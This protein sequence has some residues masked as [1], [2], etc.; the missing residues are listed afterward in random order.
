MHK[1]IGQSSFTKSAFVDHAIKAIHGKNTPAAAVT[2]LASW[3]DYEFRSRSGRMQ[4][5]WSSS[6]YRWFDGTGITMSG[7]YCETTSTT[8]TAILRSAGIAARPFALDYNKTA[9][10]GESGQIGTVFEYDHATMIWYND[11]WYAQRAY[12]GDEINNVYYPWNSGNTGAYLLHE[13]DTRSG[14]YT[15]YYGDGN[16]AV[17]ED[18]NFKT[19]EGVGTVNTAWPIPS[20]EFQAINRDYSWDSKYPLRITQ[21]PHVDTLNCQMWKGDNWAPGEWRT[22]IL[23]NP[24][25]RDETLTYYLPTGVPDPATPLE[26]WPYNPQPTACSPSTPT[27][28]CNAFKASW[29]TDTCTVVAGMVT[30][31]TPMVQIADAAHILF[32]PMMSFGNANGNRSIQIGDIIS[33]YGVDRDDDGHFDE[34]VI[35][36]EV[37]SDRVAGFQLGGLLQA[38]D[39]EIRS[40]DQFTLEKGVQTIKIVFDGQQ[41]GDHAVD[42]P[43]QVTALWA[44]DPNLAILAVIDPDGMLDYQKLSY[45]TSAFKAIEFEYLDAAF[46][47]EYSH[48]G[49]DRDG[50]GLYESIIINVPLDIKRPG[51]FL[52]EGDIYDGS[53]DFVGQAS[54]TGSDPNASLQFDVSKTQ[55]PYSL[56]HLNLIKYMGPLIDSRFAPEYLIEDL[57]GKI[58]VGAVSIGA[59]TGGMIIAGV[60][61]TGTYTF[62]LVDTN[63]NG[64]NDILRV[65]V[66]V[67]VTDSGGNYRIEGLL[68]DEYGTQVAWA[69]SAPQALSV[70][71]GTMTLD[72]DGKMLYDQLPLNGTRS[73]KLVAVKIF[74]NNLSS[75]TLESE[76]KYATTT[77]AYSRNQFE[78]SSPAITL[79]K[80]DLES[81]TDQWAL[82]GT[83]WSLDSGTWNSWTNSWKATATVN[84]SGQLIIAAP[85]DLTDYAGAVLRF[86]HAYRLGSVNDR[87]MLQISTD[88]GIT[89]NTLATYAG[90]NTTPHWIAEEV[91]LSAYGEMADVRVRFNATRASTNGLLWYVDNVYINAWP[92]VK[93]AS[94]T[95]PDEVEAGVPAT[96]T[97][98]YT[99]I[100]TSLPV[101]FK[102]NFSGEEVVTAS[103]TVNLTIPASGEI[104]VTLTVSNPYDS[105]TITQT[106]TVAANSN[107]FILTV[108]IVPSASGTVQ[109]NPDQVAF[110][111]GTSVTLTAT[112]AV[113]YT[114]GG[115]S[116]GGCS[117]SGSCTL[118][119]NE[120]KTV[121]AT[122]VPIEYTLTIAN[123]GLGEV[124]RIPDQTTYH[125]GDVVQLTAVPA[126]TYGFSHWEGDLAGS[127]NPANITIYGNKSI[128][129]VFIQ[130]YSLAANTIG[131]G[132]VTKYPD[133]VT[134]L[135][136]EQVELTAFPAVNWDFSTWNGA[137]TGGGTCSVIM[138]SNKEVTATFSQHQYNL[139]VVVTEGTTSSVIKDPD[140]A[141]Y[142]YGQR[143]IL[144]AVPETGWSFSSWTRDLTGSVNPSVI[145]IDGDKTVF[146]NFTH[147]TYSFPAATVLPSTA[148]G[149]VTKSPNATSY[150]YGAVVTVTATPKTG[151]EFDHWEGSCTGTEN[152]CVVTVDGAESVKAYFTSAYT[153]IVNTVGLGAV[154]KS[155][156]KL[157]YYYGDVVTLTPVG[158]GGWSFDSWTGDLTGNINPA[159]VTI[160]GNKNITAIFTED[161][162]L[163]SITINGSGHVDLIPP[164]LYLPEETPPSPYYTY[165]EMPNMYAIAHPGWTFSNWT[166]DRTGTSNPMAI[167]MSAD[168]YVTAHFAAIPYTFTTSAVGSGSISIN[169]EQATYIYGDVV[170]VTATPTEGWTFS[171]WSG[172]CTGSGACVV[173]VDG[174]ESVTAIFT[175]G[176]GTKTLSVAVTGSGTVTQT[177]PPPYMDGATV[178]LSPISAT[179]WHFVGWTG[180]CTGV[181]YCSVTMDADKTVGA[182]FAL[183]TYSLTVTQP[184]YGS[185]LPIEGTF[186][187]GSEVELIATPIENYHFVSW[188]GACEGQTI[189]CHVTMDSDK[190]VS[191]TFT[192][193]TF[194][195]TVTQP[196]NGSISP[197]T[198]IYDFG[199]VVELTATPLENY[200]FVEWTGA[201]SGQPTTTCSVTVDKDTAVSAVFAIDTHLLT[202][203]QTPGGTIGPATATYDYGTVVSLTATAATGYTFTQWN[204]DCT[205]QGNPCTIT[206][207]GPKYVS[208]TFTQ[209][210]RTLTIIYNP[211]EGG[212]TTVPAAGVN[213]YAYGT[214]VDVFAYPAVGYKFDHWSGSCS[215]TG[216]CRLTMSSNRTVTAWFTPVYQN[217]TIYVNPVGGGTTIP[218][219]GVNSYLEGSVVEVAATAATG[220]VFDYWS[221]ACTGSGACTVTMDMPKS[222]TAH[223]TAVF[224][225]LT[226]TVDPEGGGTTTPSVGLHTYPEG[227]VVFIIATPASGY[228]FDH[229]SGACTGSDSTCSVTMDSNKDVTA[230][231]VEYVGTYIL[232][233]TQPLNG[234]IDPTGGEYDQ[235]EI[236]VLTATADTGYH[237]VDWTGDCAEQGNPCTLTMDGDKTVSATFE[238]DA[239]TLMVNIVGSGTVA[240]E[241]DQATYTYGNEVTLTATPADGWSFS[242][243]G[244]TCPGTGSCVVT[245]DDNK[246]VTATFTQDEY[247]LTLVAGTGGTVSKTP[248]QATYHLGDTVTIAASADAGYTFSGWTDDYVGSVSP[249]DIT[250]TGDMTV[251]ANYTQDEYALTI[252]QST[253]GTIAADPAGPY[254]LNDE[255]SVTA[256]PDPGYSFTGWTGD[257]LGQGNP[258]TL[259]MDGPRPSAPPS[260]RTST[261]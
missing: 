94:F 71:N 228:V 124:T 143:V 213:T 53:G 10:H 11:T 76:A 246:S 225:D 259:V 176:T 80:D 77:P 110:D 183:N 147:P 120:N 195:L 133:K 205:G 164:G 67:T 140:Q 70:G 242:D 29:S 81:G 7:G 175:Q 6:M 145:T 83:I 84:S 238:L 101:T 60:D 230:T 165:H 169:P 155:P 4:N 163:L 170:T 166:G 93:T 90:I 255:V 102:W 24:S 112:P 149:T 256:T 187:Y 8:Y 239:Y 95:H 160:N 217:L 199:T 144:T 245:M 184:A 20:A 142:T 56:E 33:D 64:L 109:R 244:G 158:D 153:L 106:V 207:D 134:Y 226:I 257:C 253:G 201:C 168:K 103:P 173:T 78:P 69:V 194:S 50:N 200:H 35:E 129:A 198:A 126:V 192:Y 261:P 208:A 150:Y 125:Y 57:D 202:M 73:W 1:H 215:G 162:H 104:P 23:S 182:T 220:Y 118:I 68:E 45:S 152:P 28:E 137:C 248:D 39:L 92:A 222:V 179:G 34:L 216:N 48:T 139:G 251:T 3:T 79:F 127:T 191:A 30:A 203:E 132:A 40:N 5:N 227:S 241:P 121:T 98:S 19:S 61:P 91:D 154:T 115:W 52:V 119:M 234:S 237:F 85:L 15:D 185:I 108:N 63:G 99:S 38:G 42:G 117:G 214:V 75:S 2:A 188:T 58:E 107:Q 123:D 193:N 136:G 161:H 210:T 32:M 146:A 51:A 16:F 171:E 27:A 65:L 111:P 62:N 18:W 141:T 138:D 97:A 88:G 128:T 235:G 250:I 177:P 186:E 89:W 247:T 233:V 249:V 96:F 254:H 14:Y 236:V 25:G 252:T 12:G 197:E 66:G 86:D 113:G 49:V 26:N 218:T 159:T 47:G 181:G 196:A 231:F 157:T 258:C 209:L 221:G 232:T 37:T 41:I 189:P 219:A 135:P 31:S 36:V 260:R 172:S 190:T 100:D 240:K 130:G 243:W 148:A 178:E 55:P 229:W 131:S 151:W 9:G 223:F 174:N 44:A 180:D 204:G 21:S 224:H 72:F 105:A 22:P 74:R 211:A 17:N 114:F 59:S 13:W 54:W 212:G 46:T 87:G 167:T 122:F 116:G 43:Y 82:T 206:V 156:E